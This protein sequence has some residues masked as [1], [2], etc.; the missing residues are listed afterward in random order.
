MPNRTKAQ[1]SSGFRA[2][3]TY[4][5]CIKDN[6]LIDI[7]CG[8]GIFLEE[9]YQYLVDYCTEWYKLNDKEHLLVVE[10]IEPERAILSYYNSISF[11]FTELCGRSYGGGV[12][13][14]LPGEVGNIYIPKL[15][16]V[17][18]GEIRDLLGQ[19]DSIVRNNQNIEDALD[20]VVLNRKCVQMQGVFG[21][22]YSEDD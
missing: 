16:M 21:R 15:D 22:N 2:N 12:L 18:I 13:E 9:A 17:P 7:A 6:V 8:S 10:G 11:A 3:C 4:G 19:I 5:L 1:Q 14:I 20:I